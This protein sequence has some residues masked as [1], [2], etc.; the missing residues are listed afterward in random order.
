MVVSVFYFHYPP[1]SLFLKFFSSFTLSRVNASCVLSLLVN[2]IYAIVFLWKIFS[3][4]KG[5]GRD[6]KLVWR[7][8]LGAWDISD[9]CCTSTRTSRVQ[10][11]M[12]GHFFLVKIVHTFSS[13]STKQ[14]LRNEF[15]SRGRLAGGVLNIGCRTQCLALAQNNVR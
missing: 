13:E 5:F 11:R 4:K 8:S 2:C 9:H 3:W 14:I 7:V 10:Q 1:F 12:F 6:V 15:V